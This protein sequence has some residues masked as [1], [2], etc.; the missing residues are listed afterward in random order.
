MISL[1]ARFTG[2]TLTVGGLAAAAALLVS[3]TAS[4][5]VADYLEPL[6]TTTCSSAQFKDTLNA[7]YPDLARALPEEKM[8]QLTT[9]LDVPVDQRQQRINERRAE[10]EQRIHDNPETAQLLQDNPQTGEVVRQIFQDVANS[11]QG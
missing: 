8:N 1:R 5:G 6:A 11:C 4:A 9:I 3:G 2:A 10:I 7:K